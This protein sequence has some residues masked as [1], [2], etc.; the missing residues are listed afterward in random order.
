M[1]TA[2]TAMKARPLASPH[3]RPVISAPKLSVVPSP[4]PRRGFLSTVFLCIFIFFG[5]LLLAFH[6]NTRMVQGA[7]EIKDIKMEL[8]SVQMQE[9]ALEERGAFLRSPKQLETQA[10]ALGMVPAANVQE[11]NIEQGAVIAAAE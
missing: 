3:S 8:T 9:E 6:F 5:A 10:A 4:A 2:A 11:I 1:S 7:Y